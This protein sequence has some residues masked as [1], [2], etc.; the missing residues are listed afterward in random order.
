MGGMEAIIAPHRSG[1][2]IDLYQTIRVG[3]GTE[4]QRDNG[5]L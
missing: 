3:R 4:Y 2:G 5:S 1:S